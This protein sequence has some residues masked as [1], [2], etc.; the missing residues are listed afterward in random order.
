MGIVVVV[1][2]DALPGGWEMK[3]GVGRKGLACA[4]KEGGETGSCSRNRLAP[5]FAGFCWLWS[6]R[7]GLLDVVYVVGATSC[8]SESVV[9]VV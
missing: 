4:L 7:V 6:G 8:P 9:R 1:A 3:V 5:G 2:M